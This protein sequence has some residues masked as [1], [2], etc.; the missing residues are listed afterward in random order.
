[1][2]GEAWW[3]GAVVVAAIAVSIMRIIFKVRSQEAFIRNFKEEGDILLVI[4]HPDDEA[5]FFTPTIL[6]LKDSVKIHVMSLSNGDYAGLG[7][8]RA[9]ELVE[10]CRML[11][12]P[13]ERVS[14]VDDPSLQDGPTNS[15]SAETISLYVLPYLKKNGISVVITFDDYGISGHPNHIALHTAFV[16]LVQTKRIEK[17]KAWK[18][19]SVNLLRKYLGP[20]SVLENDA[21]QWLG[22]N[23]ST[24]QTVYCWDLGSVWKCLKAHGSQCEWFRHLFIVFGR[25]SYMNTL[26]LVEG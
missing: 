15:W 1:M 3:I 14:V 12:I 16:K 26:D 5:M 8:V 21:L 19:Q 20:L 6:A 11:G 4:A 9:S 23:S 25:Y 13:K 10:S 7:W 2:G 24:S 17:G 22:S 18:L